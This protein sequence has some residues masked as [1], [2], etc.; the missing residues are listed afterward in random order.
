ME[1]FKVGIVSQPKYILTTMEDTNIIQCN[2]IRYLWYFS[3]FKFYEKLIYIGYMDGQNISPS[4]N[5][6]THGYNRCMS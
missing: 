6:L 5:K 2:I 3:E 4:H 1:T